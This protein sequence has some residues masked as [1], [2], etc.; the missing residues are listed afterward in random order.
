MS[1]GASELDDLLAQCDAY[2]ASAREEL[3]LMRPQLLAL[4]ELYAGY[5]DSIHQLLF[6]AAPRLP[7]GRYANLPPAVEQE[8]EAAVVRVLERHLA[9]VNKAIGEKQ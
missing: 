5:I 4:R 9:K 8:C 6:V 7:S 1:S 2:A 3:E